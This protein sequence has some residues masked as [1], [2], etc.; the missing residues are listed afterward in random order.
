M[1]IKYI[2][3]TPENKIMAHSIKIEEMTTIP[4]WTTN[5]QP[6]VTPCIQD[7]QTWV[8]DDQNQVL[9]NPQAATTITD[10][11]GNLVMAQ[12]VDTR[13]VEVEMRNVLPPPPIDDTRNVLP[14]GGDTRHVVDSRQPPISIQNSPLGAE[15]CRAFSIIWE[16]INGARG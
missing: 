5:N 9:Y 4:T 7:G 15:L 10:C 14:Q 11:C 3:N 16:I 2:Y 13:C 6:I 1:Y 8:I 12:Q